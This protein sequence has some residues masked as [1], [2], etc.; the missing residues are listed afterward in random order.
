MLYFTHR[1][2]SNWH[3]HVVIM[4]ASGESGTLSSSA[5]ATNSSTEP[6]ALLE[7]LDVELTCQPTPD[8]V[9]RLQQLADEGLIVTF[10]HVVRP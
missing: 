5:A 6:V 8:A 10:D 3:V 1:F 2:K 4:K 9:G 7:L